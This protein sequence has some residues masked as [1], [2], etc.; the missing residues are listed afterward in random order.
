MKSYTIKRTTARPVLSG[1]IEASAWRR[2][3]VLAIDNWPWYQQGDKQPTAARVLYDDA[4]IYV[5]FQCTDRH[6]YSRTTELNGPVYKDSCVEFFA[7][8]QPDVEPDY[9]NFEANCCGV[10]HVGFGPG[11][12]DRNL[13][14]P[15]LASQIEVAG[16][17]PGPTRDESPN[18]ANWWL[19]ARLPFDTLGRFT[20]RAI[21]PKPADRWRANFY[22]IGGKTDVQHACWNRI[23]VPRADFH[24]PEYFGQVIFE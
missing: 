21:A 22:R 9:F 13:I 23:E 8:V 15:E 16:S 2:A 18:D 12:K 20:G 5:Q 24:R 10:F 4:A 1:Q 3:D 6:I 11:R 17:E 7:M 14:S 19:A